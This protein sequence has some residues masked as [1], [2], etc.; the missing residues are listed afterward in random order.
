MLILHLDDHRLLTQ[1]IKRCVCSQFVGCNY[2][3]FLHPDSALEFIQQAMK[4]GIKID[5]IITDYTHLGLN[6]YE[7]AKTVSQIE[8]GCDAPIVQQGCAEKVFDKCR[9]S[10]YRFPLE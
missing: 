1:G 10:K 8:D 3:S 2:E 6:G 4:S 9:N 5:L 7:F